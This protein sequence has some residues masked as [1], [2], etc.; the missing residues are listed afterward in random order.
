MSSGQAGVWATAIARVRSTTSIHD[1]VSLQAIA[2]VAQ[3]WL[4]IMHDPMEQLWFL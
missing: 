2:R 4:V 3:Q 1:A